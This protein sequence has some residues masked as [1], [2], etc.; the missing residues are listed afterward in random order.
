[1]KLAFM[2]QSRDCAAGTDEVFLVDRMTLSLC[3]LFSPDGLHALL[4]RG[5]YLPRVSFRQAPCCGD[6]APQERGQRVVRR[7]AP[8]RGQVLIGLRGQLLIGQNPDL[9]DS[10]P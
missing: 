10:R 9:I 5:L 7:G 1:M 3:K 8:A 4:R 6:G 2:T